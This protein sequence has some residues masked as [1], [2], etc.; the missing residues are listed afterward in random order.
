[1]NYI[2]K[3]H[4]LNIVEYKPCK[5]SINFGRKRFFLTFPFTYFFIHRCR[6]YFNMLRFAANIKPINPH[7]YQF[8]K[9]IA[10]PFNNIGTDGDV[11]LGNFVPNTDEDAVQRFWNSRFTKSDTWDITYAYKRLLNCKLETILEMWQHN[12]LKLITYE[13]VNKIVRQ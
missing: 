3:S 8:D 13:T 9:L 2:F 12:K 7:K 6:R 10:L 1:M 4:D 5:R 11:C